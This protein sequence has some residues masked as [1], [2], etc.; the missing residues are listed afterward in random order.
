MTVR[1]AQRGAH[2]AWEG[3][4]HGGR[5]GGEDSDEHEREGEEIAMSWKAKYL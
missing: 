4:C 1:A 2:R 5:R 3:R